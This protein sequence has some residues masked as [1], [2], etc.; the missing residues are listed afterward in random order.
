MAAST[1]RSLP[2][3]IRRAIIVALAVALAAVT[4][5]PSWGQ[6][7]PLAGAPRWEYGQFEWVRDMPAGPEVARWTVGDSVT[8]S[9]KSLD[10]LV[11]LVARRRSPKTETQ[12]TF[13]AWL[14]ETGWEMV[15]CRQVDPTDAARSMTMSCWFKRPRTP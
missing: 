15:S 5:G 10:N 8:V 14:G 4:A 1:I 13:F 6:R 2:P 3:T 7:L 11:E 12:H 9:T